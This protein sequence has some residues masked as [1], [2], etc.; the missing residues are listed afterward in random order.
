MRTARCADNCAWLIHPRADPAPVSGPILWA[1]PNSRIHH[2]LYCWARIDQPPRG[3]P[4]RI[5]SS[6]SCRRA[7]DAER[8]RILRRRR[9]GL[10]TVTRRAA[11]PVQRGG[12]EPLIRRLAKQLA[13]EIWPEVELS[14][15]DIANLTII[16]RAGF[17][18]A[19]KIRDALRMDPRPALPQSVWET[20]HR[21]TAQVAIH[22]R[23][24]AQ[25]TAWDVYS[26]AGLAVDPHTGAWVRRR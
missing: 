2:C 8:R 3:R 20:L 5:C 22:E 9:A 13:L 11:E 4:R 18:N 12:R 26:E 24:A 17:E 6:P 16:M 10:Q 15:D 23:E 21:L 19:R 7:A 14:H 25:R 1:M